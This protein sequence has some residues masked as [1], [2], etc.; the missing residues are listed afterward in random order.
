[1]EHLLPGAIADCHAAAQP[2][3]TITHYR[4]FTARQT[5]MY[6]NTARLDDNAAARVARSVCH[7]DFCLKRRLWTVPGLE[8]EEAEA[9]SCV[10]CLEPCALLLEFAGKAWR[11]EQTSEVERRFNESEAATIQAALE[12]ALSE[13]GEGAADREADFSDPLNPRRLRYVLS[14]WREDGF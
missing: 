7:L 12:K 8:A 14:R 10:P 1:M 11:W 6:R 5:G 3:G 4:E 9:K 2:G 13:R